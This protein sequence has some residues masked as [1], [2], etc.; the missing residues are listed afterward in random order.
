MAEVENLVNEKIQEE[1]PVFATLMPKEEA[2]KLGAEQEFGVK[3]GDQVTVYSMGPKDAT[4]EN[5]KFS[6]SFSIEFCGGPHVSNTKE[7]ADGGKSFRIVKE[8]SVAAGIRRIR[9]VLT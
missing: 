4:A 6:E 1:L 3:Y 7:L 5:P 8:E 2:M 9:A